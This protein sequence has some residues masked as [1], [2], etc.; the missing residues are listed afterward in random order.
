M[1]AKDLALYCAHVADLKQGEDILVLDVSK[2]STITSFFVIITGRVDKHVKAIADEVEEKVDQ[3]KIDCYHRDSDES[4]KWIILD[5][6]D[7]M[8]HVFGREAR[9]FYKLE[10]LWGDADEL[11]WK[12]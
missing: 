7:V 4:L 9:D 8:V 5:Y 12:S 6:L 11:E 2:I 1:E 10:Q 3:K